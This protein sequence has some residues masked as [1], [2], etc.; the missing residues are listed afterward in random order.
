MK[1]ITL[2]FLSLIFFHCLFAQEQQ[3]TITPLQFNSLSEIKYISSPAVSFDGKHLTFITLQNNIY[4]IYE[5]NL[6][7]KKWSE[8]KEISSINKTLGPNTYK[9]SPIFNYNASKIYFEALNKDNTDI[10]YCE[11]KDGQWT[12]PKLMPKTI[13]SSQNEAQPD[14]SSDDNS[15]YFVRFNNPKKKEC[16]KIFLSK[17]NNKH[18]WTKPKELIAPINLG[19]EQYPRIL[20][21][22][23][24]L[25]FCSKRN[26]DKKF[27]IYYTKNIYGNFWF[28]PQQIN[29][30]DK[31]NNLSPS[32]D[33]NGKILYFAS[34]KNSKK[35]QIYFT[36]LPPKY[37]PDKIYIIT[38][39]ITDKNNKPIKASISLLDPISVESLGLYFN[40]PKTG[41]YKIFVPQNSTYLIDFTAKNYS[42]VF[43]NYSNK[44]STKNIDTINIKLFNT[45]NLKLNIFDKD[46]FE[47]LNAQIKITDKNTGKILN[48]KPKKIDIGKLKFKLPIGKNYQFYI[49]GTYT[50]PYKLNIDLSNVVI[51]DSFEK[52]AEITSEKVPFTFIVKDKLDNKAISCNITLI[53]KK[54]KKKVTTTVKTDKNGR[55]V[56]YARKGSV[57]DVTIN[58]QGYAFY[59][60]EFSVTNNQPKT[61]DVKLQ[62]LKQNTKI[63]LNNITFETN[64][65]DLNIESYKELDKV[66]EL[67]NKNPNIKVEISAHT[68]DVG[69]EQYNLKLSQ[70][71]AKSVVDYLIM[72][73]IPKDRLIAKGYGES[74]PLV[75]NTSDKNRAINRRVELKIIKITK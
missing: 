37:K 62:P 42:H 9:N 50:K 14:I 72:H 58:P 49:T 63:E 71:R 74:Q 55:V 28:I 52:N 68:D 60:S 15:F 13:N 39:K 45:V 8:P 33:Y 47:P 36:K 70:K 57:Y 17:K 48:I 61:F 65:A 66:I 18:Q 38:G 32:T 16:G 24:T 69:S 29:L 44:K 73:D 12:K 67:M 11:K 27:K 4:T 30:P 41:K 35:S 56:V 21:D 46:I 59:S 31:N 2:L 10:Y 26:K 3:Q 5:S 54:T 6:I 53:D 7:Q 40:N 22:N 1:K 75:P 43:V 25:I 23:K 19:C 51:F 34:V 20:S 64:S